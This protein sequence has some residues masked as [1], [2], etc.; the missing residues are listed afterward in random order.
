MRRSDVLASSATAIARK[1]LMNPIGSAWKLPPDSTSSPK[2]SGLS[3]T[4]L[5]AAPSTSRAWRNVCS[6]APNTC[7]M[8]R[9]A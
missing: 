6:T 1:S 5:M 4:P 7:G 3:E 8:Q 2:I 9:T